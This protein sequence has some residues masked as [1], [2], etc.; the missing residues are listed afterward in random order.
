MDLLREARRNRGL[1][2]LGLALAVGTTEG[3]YRRIEAGNATPSLDLL[4]KMLQVLRLTDPM[5]I[6]YRLD[7]VQVVTRDD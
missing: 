3:Y 1:T 7:V 5:E 6:G 2:Q 4:N